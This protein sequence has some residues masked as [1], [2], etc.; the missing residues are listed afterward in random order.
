MAPEKSGLHACGQADR[1]IALE[2][3]EGQGPQEAFKKDSR[4]LYWV[5]AWGFSPEARRGSQ[6]ASRAAPGKSRLHARGEGER[7]LALE[8]REETRASRR[9]EGLSTPGSPEG[10]TEGPGTASSEPL[11]PS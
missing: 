4:G 9:I 5:G 8:S 11:L 2:S 3:W 1:V 10:N 6:G 7:V